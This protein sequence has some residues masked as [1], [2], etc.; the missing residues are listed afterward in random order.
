MRRYENLEFWKK[1]HTFTLKIYTILNALPQHE[2]YNLVSQMRRASVSICANIVEG[3]VKSSNPDFKRYLEISLGSA[4]ECE[5]Y[6]ILMRDLNYIG[7]ELYSEL[8]NS[9]IDIKKMIFSYTKSL[10]ARSN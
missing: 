4:S 3:S 5:Y 7:P 2:R 1:S 8:H 10:V 9:I 6:L